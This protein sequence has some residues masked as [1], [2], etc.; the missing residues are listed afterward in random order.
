MSRLGIESAG[1]A[2][3]ATIAIEMVARVIDMCIHARK[4]RSLAKKTFGSILT[5]TDLG[6]FR[7]LPSPTAWYLFCGLLEKKFGNHEAE[8][9]DDTFGTA[10][11]AAYDS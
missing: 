6:L 1:W 8:A 10:L 5:G 3:Y 9:C 4:V 7:L 11:G 2:T